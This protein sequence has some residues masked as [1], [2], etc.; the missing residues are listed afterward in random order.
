[1]HY[2]NPERPDQTWIEREHFNSDSISADSWKI[3]G[4]FSLT[5]LALRLWRRKLLGG[6]LSQRARSIFEGSDETGLTLSLLILCFLPR[7]TEG[8]HVPASILMAEIV[9][10]AVFAAALHRGR[11]E[12]P[13]TSRVSVIAFAMSLVLVSASAFAVGGEGL[14][15][16]RRVTWKKMKHVHP[17]AYIVQP[18]RQ[19]SS[20]TFV[21][22]SPVTISLGAPFFLEGR[23][24]REQ[25]VT[26]DF[27][28]PPQGTLDIVFQQQSFLSRG[29]PVGEELP[30]QRRLLRLS[31]G[32]H[33][34]WGFGRGVRRDPSPFYRVHGTLST[35]EENHVELHSDS[36]GAR[37]L[38]NGE[39]TLLPG[40]DLL[41]FGETGFMT[42]DTAVTLTSVRVEPTAAQSAR[43]SSYP[44]LGAGLP[45]LFAAAV[46]FLLRFSGGGNGIEAAA[47]GLS[48]FFPAAFYLSAALFLGRGNLF[49]LGDDRFLSQDILLAAAAIALLFPVVLFRRR[50]RGAAL[51]YNLSIL[52]ALL[53]LALFFWDLLPAE[54]ELKLKFNREAVAPGKLV[55]KKK[56]RRP[57]YSNSRSIG[58]N[59]YMWKQRLGGRPAIPDKTEGTI[60]ILALGGSQ[61]WGSGAASSRE[62]YDAILE[63]KLRKRGLPVE[64]F[65]GGVNGAGI[66]K[67]KNF[68]QYPLARYSPDILIV[69]IGLN[70]SAAVQIVKGEKRAYRHMNILTSLFEELINLCAKQG[71][72]V[73]L[74]LEPMSRETP[75]RPHSEYYRRIEKIGR[76]RAAAVID[77]G[78]VMRELESDH[79]VWWDTAHLAPYGH[80]TLAGLLEP[81]VAGLVE[82][83]IRG[84]SD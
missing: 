33:V 36:T 1:M 9:C 70:D 58:S 6:F 71:V 75:L 72:S 82:Q 14:G 28:L 74:V 84:S 62:T 42:W 66:G 79:F 2:R 83:R 41:N 65:N 61:A 30:L 44:L 73:V 35:Q 18:D 26:A 23:A 38:L 63:K 53:A 25:K 5:V 24:Y 11:S 34:P 8:F 20:S 21:S 76:E 10:L 19:R 17:D 39:E 56:S 45:L 43:E 47:S 64:I 12:S 15:R 78:P 40:I 77:A 4:L 55:G 27:L 29:D 80:Q 16:S 59:N 69:D 3:I 49:F 60:R 48:A 57:W 22:D 81:A 7:A 50:L 13:E 32:E 51:I 68:F 54:N 37:V 31:A 46:W 67:V 52:G